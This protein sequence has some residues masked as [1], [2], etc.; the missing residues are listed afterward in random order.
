MAV[1]SESTTGLEG[2]L[3]ER[4]GSVAL[5]SSKLASSPLNCKTPAEGAEST[6]KPE[7]LLAAAHSSCFSMALSHALAQQG[8]PAESLSVT[9]TVSFVPGTGITKSALDVEGTVPGVDEASFREAAEQAKQNCP[10]SQAL[11]GNVELSVTARLA[12]A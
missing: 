11:K 9:A 4:S 6:T 12:G 2:S 10:V 7:E 8:T 5:D 3:M 1:T